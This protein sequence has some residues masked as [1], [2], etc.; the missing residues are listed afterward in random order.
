[1]PFTGKYSFGAGADLP[2]IAEDVGDL[3]GIVSPYEAPLLD[4]LGDPGRSAG[5]TVHEWL[6]DELAPN[7][8]TVTSTS[9]APNGQDA[10]LFNVANGARFRIGDVVRA[11]SSREVLLV[12]DVTGNALTVVRR[13]GGTAA[14]TLTGTTRLTILGSPR[15]EGDDAAAPRIFSRVR[16]RNWTQIF[17]A[18]VSVSGTLAAARLA[19]VDDELEYQKTNRL[20][21]LVRDL[22]NTVIN[23]VA[24]GITQQGSTSVRRTMNGIIPLLTTNTFAPG[25]GAI[26]AGGGSGSDLNEAVLGAALRAVWESSSGRVDTVLVGGLL[27]RRINAFLNASRQSGPATTTY[28]EVVSMYE[29]DF[30]MARVVASRWVPPD[31]CVLLDSSRL[32]VLPLGGRSFQYRELGNTGDSRQGQLVGEYTL[33][34]RNEAAHGVIRGL[35]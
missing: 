30:G 1:M 31:A 22:E 26:P 5:S 15:L 34:M 10:T 35:T 18:T 12:A 33:E 13:Y 27:K 6:E 4:H 16:K 8:D 25:V 17:S 14:S 20:R 24:P 3:V 29:S 7:S 23:G 28:T 19:A 21:E 2:E 9:F 32:A 11:G